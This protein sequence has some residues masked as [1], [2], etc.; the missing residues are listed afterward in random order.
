M[1]WNKYLMLG[2]AGLAFA[3]CSNEEELTG[4][5][6][7]S[8]GVVEVRIVNPTT[9][10]YSG[11]STD[12]EIIVE[13]APS[14]EGE[15]GKYTIKLSAAAGDATK[16]VTKAELESTSGVVKFWN[17]KNPS[18]IEVWINEGDT[19]ALGTVSIETI[20]DYEPKYYPA[21]GSS[22]NFA[23]TGTTETND[24]KTYE[25]YKTEVEL[26][27]PVA[28]LEVS[29]I[30][31]VD[32]D[33]C[34][35]SELTI[36]G[37]YLDKISLKE[38]S[39]FEDYCMPAITSDDGTTLVDAPILQ[40]PINGNFLADGA[41]WP[42]DGSCYGFYFYPNSNQMPILKIYFANATHVNDPDQ[43]Y[44]EPR[45]AVVKS[46]NGSENYQFEKGKIYRITDV[47]LE[48]SN[49]IGDEEGN[50]YYGV[51]VTVVEA[52]WSTVDLTAGWVTQ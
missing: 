13:P 45:Y 10:M 35:Y 24:G 48:D 47:E 34:T 8:N 12:S 32:T 19:K 15:P 4:T 21:Y 11:A 29:G 14:K 2:L 6:L 9:R 49:I 30:K 40:Y 39:D 3:A 33:P 16:E 7:S 43:V 31:H 44:S 1:K 36:D 28:R 50:N 23:L 27:L 25:M 26:K 52:K 42:N 17:V 37:I 18:K 38:G 22:E 20:Q 41:V 46:Y 5:N 51:N